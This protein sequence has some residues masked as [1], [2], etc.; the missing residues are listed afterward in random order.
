VTQRPRVVHDAFALSGVLLQALEA[1]APAYP[2]LRQRLSHT[3]LDLLDALTLAAASP[4]PHPRLL[5]ADEAL[6]LL[7]AQLRLALELGLLDADLY[8][9]FIAQADLVGRQLGGWLKSLHPRVA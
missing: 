6:T 9:D 8:R 4:E 5:D 7:R 1:T 2:A 3:G